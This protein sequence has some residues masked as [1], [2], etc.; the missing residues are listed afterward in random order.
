MGSVLLS[1][2]NILSS[3]ASMAEWPLVEAVPTLKYLPSRIVSLRGYL[4]TSFQIR[5]EENRKIEKEMQRA[6][7]LDPDSARLGKRKAE[8]CGGDGGS[9]LK[10]RC[11]AY[12]PSLALE[13]ALAFV[14][15]RTPLPR[16]GMPNG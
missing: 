16:G 1:S 7:P 6:S 3:L 5:P 2:S 11:F 15:L 8:S 13:L 10:C 14:F 4:R 9:E 12:P